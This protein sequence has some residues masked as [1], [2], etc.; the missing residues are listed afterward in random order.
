MFLDLK[1]NVGSWLLVVYNKKNQENLK[2]LFLS[3]LAN[4]SKFILR[5]KTLL[6][7]DLLELEF[8]GNLVYKFRILIGKNAV[9]IILKR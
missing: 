3:Y 5:L 2:Q 1:R 9:L 7:Q 4:L 8:Y 6:L